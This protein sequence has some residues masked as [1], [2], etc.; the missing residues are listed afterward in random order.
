MDTNFAE[1]LNEIRCTTMVHS[2]VFARKITNRAQR[3]VVDAYVR[4]LT[5]FGLAM[6]LT[7][8]LLTSKSNHL[9]FVSKCTN[10]VNSVYKSDL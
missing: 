9:I 5:T 3:K 6:N 1:N 7:F 10:I 2:Y 8:D 4:F